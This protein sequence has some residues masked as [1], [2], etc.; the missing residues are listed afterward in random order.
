M[1]IGRKGRDMADWCHDTADIGPRVGTWL[2]QAYPGCAAKNAARD[3]DVS[4]RQ[5]KRWLSGERPNTERLT[6]M[7]R[8]W[9]WRFMHFVYEGILP[10]PT[11]E[12]HARLDHLTTELAA[13]RKDLRGEG[14]D[15]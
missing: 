9:G 3:F 8:K 1:A 15:E 4:E 2:R 6:L 5:A 10:P 11:D 12:I 13:L 14:H 7:G